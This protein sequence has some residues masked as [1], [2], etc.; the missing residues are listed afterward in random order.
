M[1]AD[2]IRTQALNLARAENERLVK[3]RKALETANIS[4]VE[5]QK[6]RM[7]IDRESQAI[8]ELLGRLN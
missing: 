1:K 2:Q 5:Y 8:W 6:R 7:E 3:R 4:Q